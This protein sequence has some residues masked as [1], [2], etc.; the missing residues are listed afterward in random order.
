MGVYTLRVYSPYQLNFDTDFIFQK[1]VRLL[2]SAEFMKEKR[3]AQDLSIQFFP[4]GGYL[5]DGLKSKLAF[6]IEG[7]DDP[8]QFKGTIKNGKGEVVSNFKIWNKNIGRVDITP[9][10]GESYTACLLYTS[11]AADE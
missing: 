6:K 2:N 11:D 5:V 1:E 4:E 10:R 7:V 8:D 3:K 9:K